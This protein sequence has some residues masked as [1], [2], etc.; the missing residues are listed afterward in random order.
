MLRR[1][2]ARIEANSNSR[3]IQRRLILLFIGLIFSIP[4]VNAYI[5]PGTASIFW[6]LMLSVLLAA[7]YFVHVYWIKIR[8]LPRKVLGKSEN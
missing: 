3:P 1:H 2:M 6:Q 5:N 8:E 4:H 7:A